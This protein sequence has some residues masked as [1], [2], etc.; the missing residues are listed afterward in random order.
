MQ[1]G[2]CSMRRYKDLQSMGILTNAIENNDIKNFTKI[3]INLGRSFFS[4]SNDYS[5]TLYA[6]S[7]KRKR[8]KIFDF[9]LSFHARDDEGTI[10]ALEHVL[11]NQNSV[12][13][14]F[15]NELLKKYSSVTNDENLLFTAAT[16]K[17]P[18]ATKLLLDKG[19]DANAQFGDWTPLHRALMIDPDNRNEELITTLLCY[20]ADPSVEA[21]NGYNCFE[22]AVRNKHTDFV[23]EMLFDFTF[24]YH[25]HHKLHIS[26]LLQLGKLKSPLFHQLLKHHVE[27]F[28]DDNTRTPFSENLSDLLQLEFDYFKIIFEEYNSIC[29]QIFEN[30]ILDYFKSEPR[31]RKYFLRK[32]LPDIERCLCG[33]QTV[34][35]LNLL[36]HGPASLNKNVIDFI[37]T[38]DSYT[39]FSYLSESSNQTE[40]TEIFVYLFIYG[41]RIKSSLFDRVFEE[42]GYCELFKLLLF[43]D[44]ERKDYGVIHPSALVF[45]ICEIN[46]TLDTLSLG[47]YTV[48]S[49]FELMNYFVHPKLDKYRSREVPSKKLAIKENYPHMPSLVEL[50][51]NTFREYF[52]TKLDIRSTQQF[53]TLLNSLPISVDHKKIIS[54]E[55]KLYDNY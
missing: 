25:L 29:C 30:H 53:Y 15:V 48:D 39:V 10:A 35:K 41:L 46:S 34:M 17:C 16:V 1:C 33:E 47:K 42:Y 55:T 4:G 18:Q 38:L 7:M 37:S 8:K 5:F 24:D 43:L 23:R 12:P 36:L 51:R 40:V 28:L 21:Y 2:T 27:F 31:F 45:Y 26:V 19:L 32:R 11:K 49:V 22:L 50:A 6:E 20:G 44:Y 52:V 3:V 54:L 13:D 14:Y 9:L